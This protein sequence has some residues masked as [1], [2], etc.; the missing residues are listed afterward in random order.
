M[1][2]LPRQ[3]SIRREVFNYTMSGLFLYPTLVI[4]YLMTGLGTTTSLIAAT[5][6]VLG[7][8]V[9]SVGFTVYLFRTDS[10]ADSN[11]SPSA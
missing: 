3:T 8:L 6:T 7:L 1:T 4:V 10:A 11:S 9:V 5:A 2:A